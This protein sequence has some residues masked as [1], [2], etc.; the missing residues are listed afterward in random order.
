MSCLRRKLAVRPELQQPDWSQAP[1][2]RK[3]LPALFVA[4][5]NERSEADRE[6][7][8]I[9]ARRSYQ[10]FIETILRWSTVPTRP[11]AVSATSGSSYLERTHG[12]S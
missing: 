4:A 2:G 8:A 11:C 12:S 9:M 3:L 1:E 7:V 6:I 10:E 5:W